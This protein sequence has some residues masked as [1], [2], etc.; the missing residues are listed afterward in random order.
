MPCGTTKK[1]SILLIRKLYTLMQSLGPLPEAFCLSMKL[2]YYD[3]GKTVQ[4][5]LGKALILLNVT[6]VLLSLHPIF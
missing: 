3:D 2:E 6:V 4:H 1:A 5:S